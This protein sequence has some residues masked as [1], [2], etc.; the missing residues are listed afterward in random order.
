MLIMKKLIPAALV[1]SSL[2]PF[3]AHAEWS[4]FSRNQNPGTFVLAPAPAPNRFSFSPGRA[5][6]PSSHAT[7]EALPSFVKIVPQSA[8]NY[9]EAMSGD[10]G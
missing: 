10:G 6:V 4:G 8:P 9:T 1:L 2:L 5:F 3:A 7:V